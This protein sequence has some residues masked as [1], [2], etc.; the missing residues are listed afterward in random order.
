MSNYKSIDEIICDLH[1]AMII[2]QYIN[3]V[4][5]YIP[6]METPGGILVKRAVDILKDRVPDV[7]LEINEMKPNFRD[8]KKFYYEIGVDK[9]ITINQLLINTVAE[10]IIDCE[11]P[12][13]VMCFY[14]DCNEHIF[15]YISKSED[16]IF[17]VYFKT[18]FTSS[19][20][21]LED[22]VLIITEDIGVDLYEIVKETIKDINNID[23]IFNTNHNMKGNDNGCQGT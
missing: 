2:R 12:T 10:H 6:N 8:L 20:P 15:E 14:R 9:F 16:N 17:S 11:F 19:F 21:K 22:N 13:F 3:Y 1:E 4:D 7:N 23:N 5:F 18:L